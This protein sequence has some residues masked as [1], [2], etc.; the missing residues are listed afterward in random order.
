MLLS[1]SP[2][3]PNTVISLPVETFLAAFESLGQDLPYSTAVEVVEF[4][5][6]RPDLVRVHAN[7]LV[8]R[9][10]QK[11]IAVGKG[12]AMAGRIGTRARREIEKLVGQR[13]H[14]QLFVK[15]DPRWLKTAKRIEGLGYR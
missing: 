3:H 6:S 8:E 14:L 10:S 4:D 12:G 1:L 15:V 7:L 11:R 13:V 9:N 5:E 2:P